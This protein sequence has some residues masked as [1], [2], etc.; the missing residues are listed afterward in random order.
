MVNWVEE[1]SKK[2]IIRIGLYTWSDIDYNDL[3]EKEGL[4]YE[5]RLFTGKVVG[6]EQ[7]KIIKERKEAEWLN[8][9]GMLK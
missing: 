4:Y 8:F 3:I 2:Y 9:I 7:G 1:L 5:S 6:K